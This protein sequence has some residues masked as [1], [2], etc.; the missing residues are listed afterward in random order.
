[1]DNFKGV[2]LAQGRTAFW[3]PKS[4]THLTVSSNK[5]LFTEDEIENVDL[6]NIVSGINSGVLTKISDKK[7]EN[8]VK[9]DEDILDEEQENE[10]ELDITT[11]E[12]ETDEEETDEE[13]VSLT[14]DGEPRCQEIKKD[15]TQCTLD[16]KYPEDDPKYCG[17]HKK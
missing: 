8:D 11:D 1:M 9:T 2:K 7:E 16:A 13:L 17:I 4:R 3:D 6:S 14:E 10:E 15:G 12:E 5:R